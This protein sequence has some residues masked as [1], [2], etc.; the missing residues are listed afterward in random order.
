MAYQVI[1]R[2][3]RPQTFNEVVYQDHISRTLRNS[4][5]NQR[6]S[7]AYIFSG[8]R[9]VGKTT[10]ARIFAKS[11]NCVNGPTPDP[12]GKCENCLEI[13]QG[14]SFDVIEI[15]GASNNGVDNIRDLR[16]KV[17]FA[18]LKGSYKVYII[19]E[20][21]MLTEQAFNA[22]LKTLEEPPGHVVFIFATTEIHKVP[23]TI[24]SRCQKYFFKKISVEAI[25]EHLS[26]IIKDEKH[27]VDEASLYAIARSAEG[28]MRDAQS[29]LEQIISFSD[30]DI[31]EESTL[32]ILGVLPLSSYLGLL[33]NIAQLS[34]K[35]LIEEINKVVELGVDIPRYAAGFI[36]IIRAVRL[37][38]NDVPLKAVLDY[39]DSEINDLKKMADKFADEELS[40]FFKIGSAMLNDLR[41]AANERVVLE[42][43]MLDMLAVKKRPSMAGLLKKIEELS[44]AEKKNSIA[45]VQTAQADI[46]P[47]KAEMMHAPKIAKTHVQAEPQIS[48][49]IKHEWIDFLAQIKIIKQYLFQKIKTAKVEFKDNNVLLSYPESGDEEY[50]NR[51]LDKHDIAFINEQLS[52][53]LNQKINV[54]FVENNQGSGKAEDIQPIQEDAPL[55]EAEMQKA[56][57]HDELKQDHPVVKKLIDIFY[58]E[59][60][61]KENKNA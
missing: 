34:P 38:N 37:V 22:L 19:D 21:H 6:I 35:G 16:E 12:C 3:W 7:H 23:E 47:P 52:Q 45:S 39:S 55:P 58:G 40:S 5:T 41:F 9:G 54:V 49:N 28:A 4:I 57:E 18:P 14:T 10:T 33:E 36:D 24:L 51:V 50:Y 25:V 20:V 27:S 42:M 61:E 32:S 2:R 29:L 60:V 8:P 53:R 11:L 31:T 1:A 43:G 30:G 48:S 17:H 44:A 26:K 13:K 46:L 59:I 15:D 56:D